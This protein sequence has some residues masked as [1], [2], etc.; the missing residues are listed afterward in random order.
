M[1]SC[2][3]FQ[4]HPEG[5]PPKLPELSCPCAF[6]FRSSSDLTP[7]EAF[8][9]VPMPPS[10]LLLPRTGFSG[11]PIQHDLSHLLGSWDMSNLVG[12]AVCFLPA[13]PGPTT[14]VSAH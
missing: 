11:S 13:Y 2:L 14:G 5:R 1:S 8:P 9:G 6:Y 7:T 10:A 3:S 4:P 12:G